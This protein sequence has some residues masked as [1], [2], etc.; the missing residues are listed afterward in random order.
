ML[1]RMWYTFESLGLESTAT[2]TFSDLLNSPRNIPRHIRSISIQPNN[3]RSSPSG[4][5]TD[6]E[7]HRNLSLLL[8]A[9]KRDSLK[10][11][12]T[13][14]GLESATFLDLLSA[15]G[16]LEQL[17]V[18]LD[19]SDMSLSANWTMWFG[20]H[21]SFIASRLTEVHDL[22]IIDHIMLSIYDDATMSH[23][24]ALVIL[25]RFFLANTPALTHLTICSDTYERTVG[26]DFLKDLLVPYENRTLFSKVD[27]LKLKNL[28]LSQVN[29][30]KRSDAI[31]RSIDIGTLHCLELDACRNF[32]VLLEDI[33]HV[34][35][36][37][38]EPL[39]SELKVRFRPQSLDT[40]GLGAVEALLNSRIKL[41]EINVH[42]AA[43]GLVEKGCI[44]R[45]ADTLQSLTLSLSQ[46][47]STHYYPLNALQAILEKCQFLEA[48]AIDL[49]H[50]GL[51]NVDECNLSW[52]LHDDAK[53]LELRKELRG[54]LVSF[55]HS[56]VTVSFRM[57]IT[58]CRNITML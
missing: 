41:R 37:L 23:Y 19:F 39:L 13:G 17:C 53:S 15:Q 16:R 35:D 54:V 47:Y 34:L 12:A 8:N 11:F 38:Q 22:T 49:P 20:T 55:V 9:L 21:K 50:H 4:S 32:A 26:P 1:P 18:Y 28:V 42:S 56:R 31:L 58:H 40:I 7:S 24:G 10:K 44:I 36:L 45:H 48:L 33:G 29:F 52:S 27:L 57:V 51:G 43:A 30:R 46:T 25:N 2:K 3:W 5:V 6:D 14:D